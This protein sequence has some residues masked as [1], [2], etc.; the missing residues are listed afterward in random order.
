M[1]LKVYTDVGE[2]K[3]VAMYAKVCEKNGDI[4]TIKYL[5]PTRD[6]ESGKVVYRYEEETYEITDDSI[7]EYIPG[8]ELNIGFVESI[9]GYVKDD[10]D[11][12]YESDSDSIESES[13]SLVESEAEEFFSE[14]INE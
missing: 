6:R 2:D 1:I 11:S 4:Y 14:D 13:E 3:P 9:D 7:M 5:S 12:D 10:S 8:D